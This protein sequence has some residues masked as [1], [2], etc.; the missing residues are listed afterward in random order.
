MIEEF[1][2]SEAFFPKK[3]H[4]DLLKKERIEKNMVTTTRVRLYFY[5]YTPGPQRDVK[6]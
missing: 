6:Q 4:D 1:Q 3:I 2:M 5:V